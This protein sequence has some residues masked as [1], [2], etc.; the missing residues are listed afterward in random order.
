[1]KNN[2]VKMIVVA[3]AF[4]HSGQMQ[5][6]TL[7]ES[8]NEALATNPEILLRASESKARADEVTQARSGYLPRVDMSAGVGYEK[9]R[10]STTIGAAVSNDGRKYAEKTRR[11]ASLTATQMLFD[12]FATS[13]EVER[14]QARKLSADMDMCTAAERTALNVTEAY[15]NV[16]RNQALVETAKDNEKQHQEVVELIRRKGESGMSSDADIAQ[17]EGRLVLAQANTISAEADLRDAQTAYHRVVGMLP[18][19]VQSPPSPE[20]MPASLDK[21]LIMAVDKH[22]V[23]KVA[24]ADV[25]AAEASYDASKS[26]YLP[27]FNLELGATWGKD[28]NGGSTTT[29][30]HTAMV[31][32]SYNL[33]NGG[34]DKARRSQTSNLMNEAQEIKN[35][36]QRQVEEEVRLAWIAAHYGE[37]RLMPLASHV[38]HAKKSRDLYEKQFQLGTRTLL[39]LLDSQREYYNAV[40]AYVDGENNLVFSRYRLMHSTG[41]LLTSLQ[42]NRPGHCSG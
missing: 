24:A 20:G 14:Q 37:N 35:R 18:G 32:M 22:P 41:S 8:V 6:A 3:L 11:E 1:M 25:K 36:A 27:E 28:Q 31:R 4:G 29:Y 26:N 9:S 5:A 15:V 33:F 21:A 38:E 42:A 7:L 40:N 19:R 13:S 10:N 12:G 23:L 2:A 30:D 17:A 16:L 39:D 34:A